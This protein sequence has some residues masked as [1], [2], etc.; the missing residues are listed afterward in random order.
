MKDYHLPQEI[1]VVEALKLDDVPAG[2]Y[3]IHC[4]PLRVPGAEGAPT[5]CILI[6]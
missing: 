1:V 6:K 4:L 2:I 3:S 5:R